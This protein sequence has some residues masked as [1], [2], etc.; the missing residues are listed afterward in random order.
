MQV[1]LVGGSNDGKRVN[2]PNDMEYINLAHMDTLEY[3]NGMNE[4]YKATGKEKNL[5]DYNKPHENQIYYKTEVYRK[6]IYHTNNKDFVIFS[7][8]SLTPEDIMVNLIEK[9]KFGLYEERYERK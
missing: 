6:Q 8:L 2:V 4:P 3:I 7:E 5:F 9:Y 1:L